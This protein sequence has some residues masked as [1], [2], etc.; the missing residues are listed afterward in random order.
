MDQGEQDRLIMMQF[1]F[2]CGCAVGFEYVNRDTIDDNWYVILD[3]VIFRIIIG[4][5]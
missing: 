3:L 1:E 2:I 4:G 5:E